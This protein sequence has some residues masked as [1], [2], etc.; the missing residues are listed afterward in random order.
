MDRRTLIMAL[1]G[2]SAPA[3]F[4]LGIG[5]QVSA[6]PI[7]SMRVA[8]EAAISGPVGV[9]EPVIE[10]ASWLTEGVHRTG[11]QIFGRRRR[12]YRRRYYRRR[13]YRRY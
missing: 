5:S 2:A 7:Q 8:G 3:G 4:V 6:M 12:Y 9:D 10:Q 11:R 1:L 13:Y